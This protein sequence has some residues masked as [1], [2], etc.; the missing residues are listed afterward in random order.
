MKLKAEEQSKR[1]PNNG[2]SAA[3]DSAAGPAR[4]VLAPSCE[5]W[6][7]FHLTR[8]GRG[9]NVV[10]SLIEYGHKKRSKQRKMPKHVLLSV[11]HLGLCWE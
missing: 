7:W 3:F 1:K 9:Q 5:M 8:S 4:E 11:L 10:Y 6:S 2:D